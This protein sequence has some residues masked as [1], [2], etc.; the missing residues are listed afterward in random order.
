M[1]ANG[2]GQE[3]SGT[4]K[5]YNAFQVYENNELI[6]GRNR[7]KL[8]FNQNLSFGGLVAEVDLIDRYSSGREFEV[9]PREIYAD[10]FTPS[11]DIRIGKQT[12]IWGKSNGAFVND[13][14]TPV[15]LREFLTQD[16]SD[17]R[18][19]V[20]A[21]N[22]RRYFE[23]SSLQVIVSPSLTTDLL[24]DSD[25]RW[26]PVQTLPSPI[27]FSFRESTH[28]NNLSNVQ[29]AARYSWRPSLSL[30]IDLMAY[31]WA[32]PMPAYS[33][34]P[35][36]FSLQ[37][38]PEVTLRETYKTSP[39]AGFALTWQRG[40]RWIFSAEGLFVNER[41]FTFLPVS[42]NRLEDA[43]ENPLEAI[44]VLQ[45]FDIRDDGYLLTKP[46][47]QQMIGVQ[48]SFSGIT[49]GL[50]GYLE[51][52]LNY[53][54][55]ILPQRLFPYISVFGQRSFLRD[56]LQL[57]TVGRYNIYGEDFWAQLQGTYE[58]A[59]GFEFSLGGNLFGGPSISPFYGHLTFQ[60]F[61]DNSFLF[62]QTAI[63][64]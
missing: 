45:E 22:I 38:L 31:H 64:F 14:L 33:I 43:L 16:M 13:I 8:Q 40:D 17:L 42:I 49:A 59:D 19:G 62:M 37:Q 25:S 54:D 2:F 41:L 32:H 39:M 6:A 29:L 50:Q 46:W 48:T 58:I 51:I 26:F 28:E 24:P 27:P 36:F 47:I 23:N 63:Y 55:R 34:R 44:P 53:E 15:D 9:F 57:F 35:R 7:F 61:R 5:N 52:I 56:R 3:F 60:Q 11:Y 20:T 10:W 4:A 30:D 1:P 18:V 12:I 21:I